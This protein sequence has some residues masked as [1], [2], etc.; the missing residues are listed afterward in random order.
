MPAHCGRMAASWWGISSGQNQNRIGR[1]VQKSGHGGLC[2]FCAVVLTG[3]GA[4][5]MESSKVMDTRKFWPL[6]YDPEGE[7]YENV[8]WDLPGFRRSNR[9][10]P[11]LKRRPAGRIRPLR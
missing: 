11:R 1:S 4:R 8:A 5:L 9:V 10:R 3:G 2:P 7:I 6:D